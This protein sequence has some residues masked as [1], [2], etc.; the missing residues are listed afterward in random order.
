MCNRYV[1]MA[2]PML[3]ASFQRLSGCTNLLSGRTN[4]LSGIGSF[5]EFVPKPFLP[6]L[7]FEGL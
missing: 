4:L 7:T 1:I 3:L 2:Q 6:V 5:V